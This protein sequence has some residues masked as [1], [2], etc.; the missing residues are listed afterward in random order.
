MC[1]YTMYATVC[2]SL[3]FTCYCIKTGGPLFAI[4]SIVLIESVY[5]CD[6][7]FVSIAMVY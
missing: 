4:P 5:E 3:I 6:K 7:K 2:T 1:L